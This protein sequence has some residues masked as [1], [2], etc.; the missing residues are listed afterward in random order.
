MRGILPPTADL[1]GSDQERVMEGFVRNC[2]VAPRA[3]EAKQ[4]V[5]FQE[6]AS[7]VVVAYLDGY[8]IIPVEE[9]ERLKAQ[10]SV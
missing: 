3:D 9:W 10:A 8:A 4:Q 5:L 1:A 7:G 2:V 6:N